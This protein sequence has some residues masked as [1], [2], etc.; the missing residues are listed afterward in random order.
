M[1]RDEYLRRIRRRRRGL[2]LAW[3]TLL[4]VCAA[5][6]WGLLRLVM[7]GPVVG[8]PAEVRAYML[9]TGPFAFSS[10]ALRRLN[11]ASP[12]SA[13]PSTAL[14]LLYWIY[15]A[16]GGLTGGLL[17]FTPVI[18]RPRIL[19]GLAWKRGLIGIAQV[20]S[21]ARCFSETRSLASKLSLLWC[22]HGLS[23][24]SLISP[25]RKTWYRRPEHQWFQL[26]FLDPETRNVLST[27][28]RF[29]TSLRGAVT[30][31]LQL[32]RF[33]E[34]LR[35]LS[36][37]FFLIASRED[38]VLRATQQPV[39]GSHGSERDILARFARTVRPAII[40]VSRVARS[41]KRLF[42][43]TSF[44]SGIIQSSLVRSALAI[45]TV[46]AGVMILGVAIFEIPKTQAFL[47]WFTVTFGSLTI[48]VGVESFRL[49]RDPERARQDAESEP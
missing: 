24:Y 19:R 20:E 7:A 38:P 34:G 37:F 31:G 9:Q 5:T 22:L 29:D 40:E 10:A 16:A 12:S 11:Q 8:I 42:R 1:T 28:S 17:V 30:L 2:R 21:A 35:A 46:A 33:L 39:R 14:V 49:P 18:R 3:V 47:T 13:F 23:L 4:L 48:S 36:D 25:V 15:F 41:R 6:A 45:S 27:L 26:R 43:L 32:D 44:I